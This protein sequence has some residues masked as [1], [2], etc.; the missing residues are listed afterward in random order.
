[1]TG[2]FTEWSHHKTELCASKGMVAARH[3]L[4]AEAGLRI[5]EQGGNA[6]DAAIAASLAGSVV[7]QAAN[8]IGGGGML[9]VSHPTKGS[10]AINYLYEAPSLAS[11][12]M[13]PL[14]AHAEPGLFGWKGIKDRLNEI[15][16]LAVG[17]PG[18][19]AG[20]H[21]ASRQFGLLDWARVV[22][23]A[24]ALAE[25]GYAM[26]WYGSLMLSVHADEMQPYSSTVK[27]FL[28]DGKYSYRP[29]VVD[30]ADVHRQ[31]ELARTLRL[32][33]E[34]GPDGFY[35]G[36][37]AKS[38]AAA[39]KAAGGV[40]S[41]ADLA[42]YAPRQSAAA[43]LLY[44]GNTVHYVPYAAP[45]AAMFLAILGCFDIS[46]Y[47]PADPRRLHLIVETLRRCWHYR[48]AFNGDSALVKGPWSGLANVEFAKAV[49]A[50]I[51]PTE[52][53]PMSSPVDPYDY[54]GDENGATSASGAPGRHEGTVHISAADSSGTMAALT[55]T[56]VGN[57]GSLVTSESGVLLNNGMI[58]FS[59]IPGQSN[60]VAPGKRPA[61]NM[62]PLIVKRPDGRP[63]LTVG[64]SGGRKIIPAVV[65]VLNL[66][67]DHG[68]GMQDAVAH[69]RLDIE[70]DKVILDSR[71]G[72]SVARQ[73]KDMGHVVELRREDLST[74]E[75]GNAC[76]ILSGDD[77]SFFSGVNPFQMTTAAGH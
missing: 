6:V 42:Q 4:S 13:F 50:T 68:L 57:F 60:S 56:V 23:P 58:G 49:A 54:S 29:A 51:S 70:G 26:D 71:F 38:I 18:S 34:S 40:L 77:G 74:F 53:R 59:P 7:Q 30:A 21:L 16:G 47:T 24:I 10:S 8:S 61:T 41:E 33:A 31:I 39:V 25:D 44:R 27:Q 45:T 3:P 52:A 69:P 66:V 5:L 75:F 9:V 14:E 65:Q 67:I 22:A 76:G 32:V 12:E 62:S 1:M 72:E 63:L 20:L 17:V 15:G 64:A 19:I 48:N 37:V 28:R 2:K 11:P 55:E 43:T 46:S 35:K 73:L 36:E